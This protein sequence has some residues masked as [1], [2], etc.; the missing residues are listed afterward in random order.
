MSFQAADADVVPG[1]RVAPDV[2][3]AAGTAVVFVEEAVTATAALD[4]GPRFVAIESRPPINAAT[5]KAGTI[6]TQILFFFFGVG[7]GGSGAAGACCGDGHAEE[8]YGA[9]GG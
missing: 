5:T 6:Q 8:G 7:V 2:L 9:A 1:A 3:F 4:F